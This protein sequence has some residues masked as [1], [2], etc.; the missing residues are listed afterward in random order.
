MKERARAFR[1][2]HG[3]ILP[4]GE[5]RGNGSAALKL[6]FNTSERRRLFRGGRSREP[7]CELIEFL[8][9]MRSN[10]SGEGKIHE[11]GR[12]GIDNEIVC[13]SIYAYVYMRRVGAGAQT[14]RT[15]RH[16]AERD[17]AVGRCAGGFIDREF[18]TWI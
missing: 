13:A 6:S 7:G 10:C 11:D 15:V 2:V 4:Y 1:A 9:K 18:I 12:K 8:I 5:L 17:A 14:W 16:A 3:E